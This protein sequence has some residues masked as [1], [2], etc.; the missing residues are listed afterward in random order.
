MQQE[1]TQKLFNRQT[2]YLGLVAVGIVL[3][4]ERNLVLVH[5]HQTRIG[6]SHPMRIA[7]EVAKNQSGA[8]EWPLGVHYPFTA[9]ESIKQLLKST[10]SL[11]QATLPVSVNCLV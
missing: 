2:H 3:P 4:L 11:R 1:T 6:D 8:A 7:T 9:I 10:G 5:G